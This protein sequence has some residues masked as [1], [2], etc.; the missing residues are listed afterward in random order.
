[1]LKVYLRSFYPLKNTKD[2][3]LNRT[4]LLDKTNEK[5][6]NKKPSKYLKEIHLDEKDVKDLMESHLISNTA[7]E[8]LKNDDYESFIHER[9]ISI[10]KRLIEVLQLKNIDISKGN[11][12]SEEI[13][14]SKNYFL[15]SDYDLVEYLDASTKYQ[16][17]FLAALVQSNKEPVIKEDVLCL[18]NEI[19]TKKLNENHKFNGFIIAG[20]KLGF[21]MRRKPLG[22]EDIIHASIHKG[23][24]YYQIKSNYKNIIVDWIKKNDLWM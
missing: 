18:M 7:L 4:L 14:F 20:A 13:K 1:M 9:E 12:V 8:F 24:N 10:K 22:K 2:S 11:M 15:W 16:K 21:K 19:G 5:I 17:L 6:S 3:I 23:N